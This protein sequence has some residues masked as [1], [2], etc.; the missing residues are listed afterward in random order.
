MGKC[1]KTVTNDQ[2]TKKISLK[3]DTPIWKYRLRK[4]VSKSLKEK[5][6]R[7]DEDIA[8]VSRIIKI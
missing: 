2:G 3:K 4:Y 5:K 1:T 8:T 6:E 7:K